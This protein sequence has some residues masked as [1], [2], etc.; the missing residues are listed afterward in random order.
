MRAHAHGGAVVAAGGGG[1]VRG[2]CSLCVVGPGNNKEY[3]I[4]DI[5][6]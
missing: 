3:S 2:D 4:D 1:V 6:S 5:I